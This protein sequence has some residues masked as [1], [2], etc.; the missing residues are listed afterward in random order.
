MCLLGLVIGSLYSRHRIGAVLRLCL[1]SFETRYLL[2]DVAFF[3]HETRSAFV[4]INLLE[5]KLP[6]YNVPARR[7]Q[8]KFLVASSSFSSPS[9]RTKL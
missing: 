3:A 5:G 6:S 8:G 1:R 4:K 7:D 9:I 2:T